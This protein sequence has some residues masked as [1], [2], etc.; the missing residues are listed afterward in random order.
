MKPVVRQQ[1]AALL[2]AMLVVTVALAATLLAAFGHGRAQRGREQRTLDLL[3]QASDALVGFAATHG[4]MPRPAPIDGDGREAAQACASETACSGELPW[5]DLGLPARDS[6]GHALRYS[7]TPEFTQAPLARV[8]AVATRR[9]QSRDASGA[10]FYTVGQ[11]AC[12]LPAPC[13]PAIVLSRGPSDWPDSADEANNLSATLGFIQRPASSDAQAPGGPFDDLLLAVPL[14][15]LYQR[16]A[17][18]RTLP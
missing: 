10:L 9:V 14:S 8:S 3:A 18:A 17:S 15:V 5:L 12:S 7:V 13:A 11:D 1:G 4:R 2:A 16:M 6:W